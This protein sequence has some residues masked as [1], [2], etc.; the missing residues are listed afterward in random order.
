ML[1]PSS[2]TSFL[3]RKCWL[4]RVGSF[5]GVYLRRSTDRGRLV[6]RF[7]QSRGPKDREGRMSLRWWSWLSWRWPPRCRSFLWLPPWRLLLRKVSIFCGRT[8]LSVRLRGGRSLRRHHRPLRFCS[9]I[10]NQHRNRPNGVARRSWRLLAQ[11]GL[12]EL[13]LE[14]LCWILRRVRWR[15]LLRRGF[16]GVGC[17]IW[18]WRIFGCRCWG[19][20]LLRCRRRWGRWRS[21]LRGCRGGGRCWLRWIFRCLDGRLPSCRS[22]RRFCL[23]ILE[24]QD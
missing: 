12:L 15:R 24:N 21:R 22:S 16:S 19:L 14:R 11:N 1:D 9:D 17:G 6:G 18:G 7:G 4:F 23:E 5:C 20:R 10:P 8:E 2:H 13:D 3:R